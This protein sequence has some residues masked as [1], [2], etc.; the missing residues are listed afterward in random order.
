MSNILL[1]IKNLIKFHLRASHLYIAKDFDPLSH[2]L[3]VQND[4][5]SQIDKDEKKLISMQMWLIVVDSSD[6]RSAATLLNKLKSARL[7][8]DSHAFAFHKG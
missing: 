3:T 4:L 7:R 5:F 8:L 2:L 6:K 1:V